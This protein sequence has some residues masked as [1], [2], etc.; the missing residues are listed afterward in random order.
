MRA[1]MEAP[2]GS[3]AVAAWGVCTE[4]G[5]IAGACD[6][7]AAAAAATGGGRARS[8]VTTYCVSGQ[9]IIVT[10]PSLA[11]RKAPWHTGAPN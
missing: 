7:A 8:V 11:N 3:H 4:G 1:S 9:D 2:T 6:A 5:Q 10:T